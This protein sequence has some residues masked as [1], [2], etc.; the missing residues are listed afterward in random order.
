[1]SG[2]H[3]HL[4]HA[5]IL[6]ALPSC[7]HAIQVCD[8]DSQPV[9]PANGNTTA[10]KTGMMRC[11]D[12]DS[13]RLVRE[14][15]LRNGVFIGVVR[16]YRDGILQR[17]Y[18]VNERGNRDGR[19]REYAATAATPNPLLLEE[20]LRNGTTV[21]QA[22]SW[23]AN[24]KLRRI[25]FHDDDGRE[26]A[27]AGFT[28]QGQLSELRCATRPLLAPDVDDAALCGHQAGK[29]VT[30]TLHAENGTPRARLNHE[31]GERRKYES[32]WDNGQ[33]R[34]QQ[35]S[36]AAGGSER[37]FSADGVKRK[38]LLW[39][40]QA[41]GTRSRRITT[42]EQEFHESGKLVRER[43]WRATDRG[44]ELQLEQTWFLNGQPKDKQEYTTVDGQSTRRETHF[45]DNGRMASEG[46][47]VVKG[48]YETQASGVHKVFDDAGRLRSERH[49]DA[50]GRVQRERELDESGAVTR[51]DE[52]FEDGSRKSLSR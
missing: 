6:L 26:L 35:E 23:H 31:R 46:A 40:A 4:R 30:A 48:R 28:P 2:M 18:Q 37:S 33:V 49:Y 10:G 1:M 52:V 27:Q 14:Q 16:Q 29:P 44:G 17:D 7:V 38:E 43:R 19:S 41:D 15:E 11:R 36:T 42:L 51:D 3:P 50:R 12:G 21:G 32:L 34:E 9:N 20:T 39:V 25:S 24:G 45:H 5:L 13:G 47:W 22:R 8:L